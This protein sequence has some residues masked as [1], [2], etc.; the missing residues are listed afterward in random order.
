LIGE[1]K[2]EQ[3]NFLAIHYAFEGDNYKAIETLKKAIE[4]NSDD[5]NAYKKLE[6]LYRELNLKDEL[7][8]VTEKLRLLKSK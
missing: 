4:I 5:Y 1:G 8:K 3:F 7:Y 2:S 6:Y